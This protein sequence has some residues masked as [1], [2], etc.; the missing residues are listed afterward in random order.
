LERKYSK[1]ADMSSKIFLSVGGC[2]PNKCFLII[3]SA[4][5]DSLSSWLMI[6]GPESLKIGVA[7][8]SN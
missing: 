6:C 8:V 3:F 7:C 1:Q 4:R 2:T 5:K